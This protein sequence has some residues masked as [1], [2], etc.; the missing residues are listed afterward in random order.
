[1]KKTRATLSADVKHEMLFFDYFMF[2][3]NRLDKISKLSF[4]AAHS[5]DDL[6]SSGLTKGKRDQL[7]QMFT[8]TKISMPLF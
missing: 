7:C 3:I 8:K 1:M 4:S 5:V 6:L 2:K